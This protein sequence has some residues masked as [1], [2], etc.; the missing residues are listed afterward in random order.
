MDI[1]NI[2]IY[3]LLIS[4]NYILINSLKLEN[5]IK[6]IANKE[7]NSFG[8]SDPTK[9]K[10]DNEDII[11]IANY[12]RIDPQDPNYFYIPIIGTSDIHGH[13]YEEEIEAGNFN[14]SRGGLDY[15][16]KYINIIRDE[17]KNQMLYLDAGDLFQGGTE[18]KITNGSI[19]L[20]Y[21]NLI[22]A[23]AS[24]FGNHEYDF[25]R[26]Y[27]EQKVRDAH[28]P[29]L[30]TNVYDTNKKTKKAFGENHFQSKVFQFKVP[31]NAEE[32]EVKIGVVGLSMEM[33]DDTISGSG[34][35]GIMFLKYKEELENEAKY[36][37]TEKG[38][39]AIVL[40]SHI[41][42]WCGEEDNLTLNMYQPSDKQE[43]C[44]QDF[45]LYKLIFALDEG[46]IDAV[47]TGHSHREIHHFIRNIPVICPVNN[48]YY[49]NI[50]YL[51]FDRKNNYKL[52]REQ[53]R[54]E[55]PLP[56]CKQIFKK[57]LKCDFL[58]E[59]QLDDYL[60]LINYTFH[61]VKIEKDPVLQPIHDKYDELFGLYNEKVCS[62]I[63]TD[64]VLGI[65]LNGSFYLG[66]IFADMQMVVT[67]A[68]I[69]IAAYGSLRTQWNPGRLPRYKLLDLLPFKNNICSFVMNGTEV[70][71]MMKI[72]QSGIRR[73]YMT[74]GL[75]QVIVKNGQDSYYLAD[76]KLFDGYKESDIISSQEYLIT[77]TNYLIEGGDDFKNIITWYKP[78]N[79]NCDYGVNLN[80]F[81][82]YLKDQKVI[83]VRKYMDNN[84]P[85][86]RFIF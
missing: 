59:S 42:L 83:D 38:V 68:D 4:L 33:S 35:E 76:I 16:A 47:V 64:E 6:N 51:A 71:K 34:Y 66:N 23:N 2:N 43:E 67:G 30:A 75:K 53:S 58:K 57:N 77:T 26:D 37:R 28:F 85:R 52:V 8:F 61:G 22:N 69:S 12:E 5:I 31:N 25:P 44:R 21:L 36:L 78:K 63:G 40:L 62:I 32:V 46:I 1:K 82:K 60:P 50:L 29:F 80:V 14:Y 79:L 10:T 72:L 13:F 73:F 41:G 20:D 7:F 81:E 55:G 17:F 56:I 19:I 49:A 54:I 24:T 86:I 27:I 70:K 15:L 9:M 3:F 11:E 84:N 39:N 18:S 74:S 45:D 48:G 65:E